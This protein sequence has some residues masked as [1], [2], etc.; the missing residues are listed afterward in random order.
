MLPELAPSGREAA[1][2]AHAS[3]LSRFRSWT[4]LGSL[5]VRSGGEASQ[6]AIRWRQKHDAYFLR[7]T[8]PFGAGLLDIEGSAAGVEARF[9]GRAAAPAPRRRRR[10]SSVEIGWS[11]PLE[12]LRYWI[13]GA[14]APRRCA[15]QD[16][17]RRPG[18]GS[19]VWSRQGGR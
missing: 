9:A 12:A 18:D 4:L 8:A 10:F 6:V 1:W 5:I 11:M 13:V 7:F 14:P 15:G 2:R 19:R 3:D 17:A 16:R